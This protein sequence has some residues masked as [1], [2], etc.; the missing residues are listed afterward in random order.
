M[1]KNEEKDTKTD[2][3]TRTTAN[4]LRRRKERNSNR[5]NKE[6]ADWESVD[7]SKIT[8]LIGLVTYH[9]GTVTFGYTRDGGAYYISYYID[10][11]SEKIYIRPTE[12]IDARL[13]DEI[14]SW[15]M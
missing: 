9:K 5:G 14:E 10:S 15:T 7:P 4:L 6:T 1:S 2:E 11:E 12:D 13:E 8:A 3:T